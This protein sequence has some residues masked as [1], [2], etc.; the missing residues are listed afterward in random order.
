MW[1]NYYRH[2]DIIVCQNSANF[3]LADAGWFATDLV[4]LACL[5]RKRALAGKKFSRGGLENEILC[6]QVT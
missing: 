3:L 4:G 1:D 6:Y 2:G 5:H